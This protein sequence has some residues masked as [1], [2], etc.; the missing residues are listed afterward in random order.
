MKYRLLYLLHMPSTNLKSGMER[1]QSVPVRAMQATVPLLTLETD[2]LN[3]ILEPTKEVVAD[4]DI[5]VKWWSRV[6]DTLEKVEDAAHRMK[7]RNDF[8]DSAIMIAITRITRALDSYCEAVSLEGH[9][10]GAKR[11]DFILFAV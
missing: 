4:M 6:I 5:M 9:S 3:A 11:S 10:G 2:V 1:G 8:D 7:G